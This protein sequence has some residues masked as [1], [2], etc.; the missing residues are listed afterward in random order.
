MALLHT[1]VNLNYSTQHSICTF[2]E[3]EKENR[4]TLYQTAIQPLTLLVITAP[5]ITFS[6]ALGNSGALN[7]S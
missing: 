1:K 3:K 7:Y 2:R 6:K 5:K 4:T